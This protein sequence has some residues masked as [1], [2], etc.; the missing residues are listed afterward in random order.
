MKESDLI[1]GY[2]RTACAEPSQPSTSTVLRWLK[3]SGSLPNCQRTKIP[4]VLM[5]RRPPR[6]RDSEFYRSGPTCQADGVKKSLPTTGRVSLPSTMNRRAAEY[7]LPA[8][9]KRG[10]RQSSGGKNA[11]S[12]FYAATRAAVQAKCRRR[13]GRFIR[14]VFFVLLSRIDLAM[15]FTEAYGALSPSRT[16][17]RIC[18]PPR[19]TSST[20]CSPGRWLSI[21][22]R[23]S[24]AL[25]TVSPL[26]PTIRSAAATS[27]FCVS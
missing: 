27:I 2:D 21:R 17:T 11:A 15:R 13:D 6:A 18:W 10:H 25:R 20:T 5:A 8:Q 14:C 22:L 4:G 19:T 12:R 23:N 1:F 16:G 7:H 24:S 26:T 9:P 3:F